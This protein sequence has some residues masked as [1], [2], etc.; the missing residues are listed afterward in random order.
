MLIQGSTAHDTTVGE[1]AKA[2]EECLKKEHYIGRCEIHPTI[3]CVVAPGT[4]LHFELNEIRLGA[5]VNKMVIPN[6]VSIGIY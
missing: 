4:N 3:R 5:W 6:I 2:A 1:R